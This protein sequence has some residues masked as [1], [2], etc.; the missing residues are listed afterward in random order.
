MHQF[1]MTLLKNGDQVA[2][3]LSH[4]I[5]TGGITKLLNSRAVYYQGS[6]LK[7]T[8]CKTFKTTELLGIS[9]LPLR[10]VAL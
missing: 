2:H 5:Q 10:L 4:G 7:E 1:S 6:I 9:K 8:P 3:R